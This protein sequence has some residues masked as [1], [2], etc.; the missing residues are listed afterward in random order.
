MCCYTH[1]DYTW[2]VFTG[3]ATDKTYCDDCEIHFKKPETYQAHRL[4]YCKS[5]VD[6]PDTG[7]ETET[8]SLPDPPSTTKVLM[9]IMIRHVIGH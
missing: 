9:H 6:S 3:S 5:R 8:R 7:S 2:V 1:V 4:H